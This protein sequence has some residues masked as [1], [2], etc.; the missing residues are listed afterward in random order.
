MSY[1]I[2]IKNQPDFLYVEAE[3]NRSLEVI[4]ELARDILKASNKYKNPRVL[5]DVRELEGRLKVIDAY[6]IPQS[7]F[8]K[9]RGLGIEK[10]AIVDIPVSKNDF[11][12]LETVAVNRGYNF[13]I[14]GEFKEAKEWLCAIS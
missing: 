3:G 1:S 7:L 2:K 11:N 5:I 14:F 9:L 13:R 4:M 10:A 8:P 12:F 6:E